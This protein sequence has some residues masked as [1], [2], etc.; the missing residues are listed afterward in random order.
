MLMAAQ[1]VGEERLAVAACGRMDKVLQE[2]SGRY[3]SR[4]EN[5]AWWYRT[6]FHSVGFAPRNKVDLYFADVAD[7]EDD[8]RLSWN[9]TGNFGGFRAG[10]WHG[11]NGSS[12]FSSAQKQAGVLLEVEKSAFDGRVRVRF[13]GIAHSV[14]WLSREASPEA[15]GLT[16]TSVEDRSGGKVVL[17]NGFEFE[18][19][20]TALEHS[21]EWTKV[22]FWAQVPDNEDT[23]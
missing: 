15:T 3:I 1:K 20:G 13:D 9:L 6:R 7:R 22:M 2:T 18:N 5:G 4:E 19:P 8:R 10:R 11:Q 14:K 17:S 23:E 16:M 21:S 12:I